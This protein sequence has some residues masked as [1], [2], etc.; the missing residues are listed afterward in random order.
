[1]PRS[2]GDCQSVGRVVRSAAAI[3]VRHVLPAQPL[4][5]S[6]SGSDSYEAVMFHCLCYHF[7]KSSKITTGQVGLVYFVK[8]SM[9]NGQHCCPNSG[10]VVHHVIPGG[11][12]IGAE[13][14]GSQH[15]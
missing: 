2:G 15:F 11:T 3:K 13:V 14:Q 4:A 9:N 7:V 12:D 10:S 6:C 5:V 8:C 1:M